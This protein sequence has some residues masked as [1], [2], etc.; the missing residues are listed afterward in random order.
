[1]KQIHPD[2]IEDIATGA[3]V[4]GTGGGGDPYIGK[5]MALQALET[6]GPVQVCSVDELEDHDLVVPVS[7]IGAP[8]VMTEK[9]LSETELTAALD[10]LEKTL[11]RQISAVMPIEV[12]GVNSLIPLI[13]AAKKNIPV[14]DADAM[15]RAFPEAQMVTF[16]LDNLSPDPVT[17]ADEKGNAILMY[18]S[19]G[20][21]S[22]R[23]AR[24]LTVQMGGSAAMCDYALEGKDV[25]RSAIPGTLTLAEEIGRMLRIPAK[26]DPF[27]RELLR[28]LAGHRLFKGK[29]V[30]VERRVEG[31]FTRGE[32]KLEGM[33]E[34]KGDFLTLCFQNEYLAA[35][36]KDRP[37][38]STPD[39]LCL[40][41][42][43]TGEPITTE[44]LR[45]GMRVQLIALPCH[46]KWRT[47][48]GIEVAGPRSF[49][50]PFDFQPVE[51]RIRLKE[52]EGG[53][54]F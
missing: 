24:S 20:V 38:A 3:A 33:S 2:S 18:P 26:G 35:L 14:V 28:K 29:V 34:W 32:A 50:Y 8:S 31:G 16:Y 10:L 41:D 47:K 54:G 25:K 6:Y 46:D 13:V 17:L 48:K 43:E 22:E 45:Y 37:L 7:M 1:M 52:T 9:L 27:V 12:G 21:W 5:L 51:Q 53:Q 11:G 15:G 23:L 44:R 42:Q 19:D 40:L 4:L 39:L 30:D 49:G 36:V